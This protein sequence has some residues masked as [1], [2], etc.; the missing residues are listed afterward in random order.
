MKKK[1]PHICF[2]CHNYCNQRKITPLNCFKLEGAVAWVFGVHHSTVVRLADRFHTTGS[3]NERPRSGQ[4]HVTTAA[5]DQANRPSHLHDRFWPATRTAA[6]T[7]GTNHRQVSE[8]TIHNRLRGD[9]IPHLLVQCWLHH[10]VI[11]ID[12]LG[13]NIR[14]RYMVDVHM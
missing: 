5:Q 11:C 10:T 7:N 12:C 8:R 9:G 3:S 13:L 4:A 6:E 1:K 2:Q 14:D